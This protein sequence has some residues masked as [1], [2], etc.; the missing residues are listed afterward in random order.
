MGSGVHRSRV[1]YVNMAAQRLV[2]RDTTGVLME[3]PVS[4]GRNG[5]GE[6]KD[7]ECTPRG[8]HEVVEMIGADCPV[9]T[10]FVGRK[11]TGEIY[12]PELGDSERGR[13]WILTR[14]LWLGGLE[15]GRN[16][17]GEVDTRSR[18][19]YIHGSPD[20]VEMGRPGSRGCIRMRNHDILR[21]FDEVGVGTKVLIE[22]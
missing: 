7:S 21:L 9:N 16:R 13:D 12:T 15:A 4:T 10:V 22:E 11:P 1:I 17:E 8:W 14:I 20:G 2:L 6:L 5:A 3:T 19:I 18:Y